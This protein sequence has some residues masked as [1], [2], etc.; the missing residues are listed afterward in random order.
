MNVRVKRFVRVARLAQK[1][2]SLAIPSHLYCSR[3][4]QNRTVLGMFGM[5]SQMGDLDAKLER[6]VVHVPHRV[7]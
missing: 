6:V 3:D 5:Q 2:T 4:W 1:E 7:A